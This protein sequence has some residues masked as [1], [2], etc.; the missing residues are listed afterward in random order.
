MS[1]EIINVPPLAFKIIW[2][3]LYTALLFF[4]L[5]I[6]KEYP[7]KDRTIIIDLF[8]IGILLNIIWC[9]VYFYYQKLV[10]SIIIL[11]SMIIIGGFI[12]YFCWPT[13]SSSIKLNICFSIY[14]IYTLWLVFALTI[15][16]TN[17]SHK[18]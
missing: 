5:L 17:N 4:I 1:Q 2:P 9:I 13:K 8:W 15:L 3:I 12:I 18:N 14:T 7:S 11:L 16:I 10:I 6:L